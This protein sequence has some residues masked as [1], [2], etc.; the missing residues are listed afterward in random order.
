MSWWLKSPARLQNETYIMEQKFPQFQLG[1][2]KDDKY[3]HGWPVVKKGQRYWC[4]KMRSISGIIYT[5]VAVYP[6]FYPSGEI[7]TYIIDPYISSTNHRYGDG[8]LCLYSNDHGGRGQGV[9]RSSTAVSYIGWT[10][11]WYH[12]HEIYSS[13]GQWPENN[14]F[15][16]R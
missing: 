11:A 6:P 1:E 8:H 2:A 5:I 13:T 15:D 16:A 14:F 9:G 12:A 10:A 7:K 3:Y 4:G